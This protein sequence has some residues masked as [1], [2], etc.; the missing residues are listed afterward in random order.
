MQKCRNCQ[1][2][3]ACYIP[4]EYYVYRVDEYGHVKGEEAM[5]NELYQRGPFACSIAV[6]QALDDYVGGIF[7]DD[8]GDLHTVH[9]VSIVGWGEENGI[10]FWNIRNSWGS[11]WGEEGF[12]RIV[13]G[14]NNLAIES[15]CYWATALDTWTEGEKH[16]TTEDEQNDYRNDKTVYEFPQPEWSESP[17]NSDFLKEWKGC[18]VPK[19]QFSNGE[20]HKTERS[21]NSVPVDLLPKNVDWRDM[22]GRNYLSWTKNQHVPRY[23]GSCWAQGST[24][25]IADRFNILNGLDFKTLVAL[26]A[27]AVINCQAGGSCDGGDPA[28]V[29]EFAFEHGLPDSSCEQYTA[30]NLQAS[31]TDFDVCRDCSPP[32]PADGESGLENCAAM[33][34]RKYYVSEYYSVVGADQMKSELAQFGPISC[35]IEATDEFDNTYTGGIYSQHLDTVELNHE[36]SVVGYGVTEEGQEFWIGRNSWG[37]YWGEYGFFRMQMYTDNLGIEQDCTAGIASYNPNLAT[38][39]FQ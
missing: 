18:R 34:H 21:W 5:M 37:T 13:R 8:T 31:C 30:S 12:F 20:V 38:E 32:A 24:S 28:K 3:E 29:Y 4:E 26:N 39:V 22:D 11:H 7:W 33:P 27:Q 36:I 9:E 19:A 2:G 16:I 15:S 17:T 6:T 1:P 14:Q 35:G 23:C 10:P 25:A